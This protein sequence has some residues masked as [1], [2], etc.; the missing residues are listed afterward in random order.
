[1]T[2]EEKKKH[3]RYLGA[4]TSNHYGKIKRWIVTMSIIEQDWINDER[5]TAVDKFYGILEP[6][7]TLEPESVCKE[8]LAYTMYRLGKYEEADEVAPMINVLYRDF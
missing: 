7:L 2:K 6:H 5:F 8:L 4:D 3:C 1:M